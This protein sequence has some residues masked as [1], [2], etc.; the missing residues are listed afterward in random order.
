MSQLE[1]E[2]EGDVDETYRAISELLKS[3][4][5]PDKLENE[6]NESSNEA[7]ALLRLT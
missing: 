2:C 1:G 4:E 3:L 6:T 5:D 7:G